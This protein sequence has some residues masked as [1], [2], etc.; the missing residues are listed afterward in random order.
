MKIR[1]VAPGTE[2]KIKGGPADGRVVRIIMVGANCVGVGGNGQAS[3]VRPDLEVE[4]T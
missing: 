1:D 3:V 4:P 2:V